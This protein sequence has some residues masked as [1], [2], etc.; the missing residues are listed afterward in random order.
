LYE[1]N[2]TNFNH[3]GFGVLSDCKTCV[4]TEER[5]GIFELDFKYPISGIHFDD[6]KT[7][8]IVKAKSNQ[9]SSPQL[10][11][12]YS[13]SRPM[14]GYVTVFAEH[15]SYDLS[16]IA[17]Q[18]FKADNAQSAMLALSDNAVNDCP[19]SFVT[20]KNTVAPFSVATPASVR[21]KLG[22]NAGSI[23]DTY[24]GEL[25]FNN[26]TVRLHNERGTDRGV[27]IRYG[28]NMT[29]LQQ[30]ENI[31]S[32]YTA[33]Y[34]YWANQE[35]GEVVTLPEKT[36]SVPG[37][38]D[39]VKVLT[40]DFSQDLQEQPTVDTL[41]SATLSYIRSSGLGEPNVSLSVSFSQLEQSEEYKGI[42][43]LERVLLCD[44]VT[45]EFAQLGVSAKAK[46]V[47]ML[48][49]VLQDRVTSVTLGNTRANISDTIVNQGQ[50][51][52]KKPNVSDIRASSES[53]TSSLLGA[54][55][56]FVRFLDTNGDGKPDTLYIADN[57]DPALAI[58]VWRFNYEGWAASKNGYFGPFELGATL[59]DGI[60]ADFITA[61]TLNADL[62]RAG[63]LRSK[64]GSVEISIN[65][66]TMDMSVG[67]NMNIGNLSFFARTNGN[68]SV[69][70]I[71]D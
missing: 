28:K 22:G 27:T 44:T 1:S 55:G 16:G 38:F 17:V 53:I 8:R 56:G 29:D 60:I 71:G 46:V 61:G 41:R 33:I 32:V 4:V 67:S 63:T 23:I 35:T 64:D 51:I 20:D 2:E 5:N 42:A 37:N 9:I 3:N 40:R 11:R 34:P 47:R 57:E 49:D 66:S 69:R 43:L 12:I 13:I 31:A 18:P 14:A 62:I 50:E 54:N 65:N 58:K 10:F 68:V 7:R 39:F 36:I 59:S 30:D 45:V 15:I 19:F 52:G 70:W 25:E 24:G 6:I 48:Y 26:F 21:S